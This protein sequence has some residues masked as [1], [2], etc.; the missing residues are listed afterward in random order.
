MKAQK[1]TVTVARALAEMAVEK[2][3]DAKEKAAAA[4]IAR[5]MKSSEVK[6]LRD[7]YKQRNSLNTKI[8]TLI[9]AAQRKYNVS[10]YEGHGGIS[11]S[12]PR[13]TPIPKVEELK[14]EIIILNHT[15]GVS[16][17]KVVDVLVKKHT[18]KNSKTLA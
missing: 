13:R 17:D 2:I 6:Q 3:V 12:R 14:N 15:D 18:Q 16:T 9:S 7:L 11:A 4:D 10:M 1:V 5:A 8:R